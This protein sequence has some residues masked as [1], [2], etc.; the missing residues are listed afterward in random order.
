MEIGDNGPGGSLFTYTI[1]TDPDRDNIGTE[2]FSVDSD[3][4][5]NDDWMEFIIQNDPLALDENGNYQYTVIIQHQ[6]E[7]E[8]QNSFKLRS[9][10]ILEIEEPFQFLANLASLNDVMTVFPNFD[11]SNGVTEEDKIGANYDGSFTFTYEIDPDAGTLTEIAHWDGDDADHGNADGSDT[12]T[13]DPNTPNTIPDFSPPD[14]L[15]TQNEGGKCPK[16]TRH[17]YCYS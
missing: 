6:E 13:D 2:I 8:V 11:N 4:L 10:G 16:S 15:D 9:S 17:Y 3:S 14:A 1:I 12:D 7:V 5:P